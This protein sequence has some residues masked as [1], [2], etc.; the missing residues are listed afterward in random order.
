MS[1]K[2]YFLCPE[3][4][5]KMTCDILPIRADKY[6]QRILLKCQNGL[7][8]AQGEIQS[9]IDLPDGEAYI[10]AKE[11]LRAW[12]KRMKHPH[13]NNTQYCNPDQIDGQMTI[14]ELIKKEKQK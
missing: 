1:H 7:C 12:K 8:G 6:R 9:Q 11:Y 4:G 2:R 10:M 5:K 3:C 13:G 14:E